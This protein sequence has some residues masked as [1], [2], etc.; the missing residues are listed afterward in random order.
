MLNNPPPG[1]QD[2]GR[3]R[4]MLAALGLFL[5]GCNLRSGSGHVPSNESVM[6]PVQQPPQSATQPQAPT[7]PKTKVTNAAYKTV[8]RSSWTDVG[9]GRNA[10]PLGDVKYLTVHHTGEHLS[11]SG[12]SDTD[13]LQ[14]IDHHHQVNLGWAAI[15]YHYLIGRDGTI[16]EGR[17]ERWQGAHSGGDNNR[18]NLGI[19]V[20]GDFSERRPSSAQLRSLRLLLDERRKR[21][22][23]DANAIKGHRDWKNTS[24]PGDALYAWLENYRTTA[25]R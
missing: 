23:L 4:V 24:C 3:R 10:D 9:V 8:P 2:P 1:I 12:I 11:A 6:S 15:G 25:T 19:S 17:P 22:R 7:V 14:R 20:I 16:Y 5:T 18:N 13:L 21:H